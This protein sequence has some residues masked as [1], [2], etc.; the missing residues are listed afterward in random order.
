MSKHSRRETGFQR[1]AS[2]RSR[3]LL[4]WL[5]FASTTSVMLWSLT[6]GETLA[7]SLLVV[8]AMALCVL[9]GLLFWPGPRSTS[10][11][12][13][14]GLIGW[15]AACVLTTMA[16]VAALTLP[17]LDLRA[18]LTAGS[19]TA[20][21]L[22][23]GLAAIRCTAVALRSDSDDE[24]FGLE[25]GRW[26]VLGAL[27]LVSLAPLWAG[28]MAEVSLQ[29][30]PAAVDTVV[31]ISPLTHLSVAAG[32]DLLRNEW[33]YAHSNLGSL[34]FSYPGLATLL[35]AYGVAAAALLCIPLLF[36]NRRRTELDRAGAAMEPA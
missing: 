15:S 13:S 17:R 4:P 28:P 9:A 22:V 16:Q 24:H 7:P 5:M 21:M 10:N 8:I 11:P 14:P 12:A 1:P 33:M 30:W 32:N 36:R 25:T 26:I 19:A 23:T 27:L 3:L 31:A 6:R 20:L 35:V 2:G 29:R 34:Q 18:L